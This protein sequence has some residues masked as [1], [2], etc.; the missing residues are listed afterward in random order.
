MTIIPNKSVFGKLDN[1]S[2]KLDSACA[3]TKNNLL[4]VNTGVI[5][6]QWKWT[7]KGF[8]TVSLRKLDSGQQWANTN[9]EQNC[10]WRN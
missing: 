6:R 1:I 5:E 10:F 3:K 8:V 7:G 2:L 9:T 4:I